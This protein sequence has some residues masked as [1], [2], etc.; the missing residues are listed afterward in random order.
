MRWQDLRRSSNVEDRGGG[1]FGGGGFP[2]GR[3]GGIGGVGIIILVVASLLFG[4][5]PSVILQ[6]GGPLTEPGVEQSQGGETSPEARDFVAAVLGSTEETWRQVFQQQGTTYEEPRLV[7]FRGAVR[8]ECGNAQSAMGPFYCP[9]DRRVY[10]DVEFFDELTRRFKAPG[11]FAQAYVI[12]HEVGHHVQTLLG[13]SAR[14]REQQARVDRAAA[15]DLSVRL[16]LQADCF[17]GVWANR[18]D[19]AR[20]ILEQGD[21]D[22]ALKAASAIGDDNLQRQAQGRVVPDSFTHGSSAQRVR[23]FRRGL[24]T[25]QPQSC[26][27]FSVRAL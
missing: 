23:W 19:R 7:L 26:D 11:D 15:N 27:T 17:A 5:D 8:S 3:A 18:A 14:V 20:Q 4:V 1:S 13:I 22:E 16:E 24:E 25:G 21:V 6:G 9:L 12:A 10:L 2:I